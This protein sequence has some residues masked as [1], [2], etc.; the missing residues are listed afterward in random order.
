MIEELLG[1]KLITIHSGIWIEWN[2][3]E[4]N[5]ME[6]ATAPFVFIQP[7]PF[8][9]TKNKELSFW[10]AFISFD[11]I[12]QMEWKWIKKYYNSS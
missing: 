1:W 11:W 10:F 12:Q 9:Q 8:N 7:I 4:W 2:V 5:S 6:E 3:M